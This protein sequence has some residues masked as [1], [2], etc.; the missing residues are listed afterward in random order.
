MKKLVF[1]IGF[2]FLFLIFG[3]T[4]PANAVFA[5]TQEFSVQ[6]K[7]SYLI[8]YNSGKVLYQNNETKKL[9][10]AS[11]VKLMTILLTLEMSSKKN[12]A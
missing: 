1:A 4:P 11:I 2:I 12:S 5:S 9:P 7:A 6:A 3:V 8:D 10:V